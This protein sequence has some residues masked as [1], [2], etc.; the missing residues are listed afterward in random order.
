M[1]SR[2]AC[3]S[4]GRRAS[5]FRVAR[6]YGKGRRTRGESGARSPGATTRTADLPSGARAV[7]PV[8]WS[9]PCPGRRSLGRTR[10]CDRPFRCPEGRA[11]GCS[12]AELRGKRPARLSPDTFSGAP[13]SRKQTDVAEARMPEA[14]PPRPQREGAGRKAGALIRE[15]S[16]R[17]PIGRHPGVPHCRSQDATACPLPSQHQPDRKRDSDDQPTPTAC[18]PHPPRRTGAV[19]CGRP[20]PRPDRAEA[21]RRI[22]LG[23]LNGRAR[24]SSASRMSA[25]SMP[26]GYSSAIAAIRAS[27]VSARVCWPWMPSVP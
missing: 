1:C 9:R 16:T 7:S 25:V 3:R 5:P 6:V 22:Q 24:S 17:Q 14:R 26:A 2:L 4:R 20:T 18:P 19:A 12:A 8:P 23:E 15:V 10:T 13:V 21:G 11:P 27:A